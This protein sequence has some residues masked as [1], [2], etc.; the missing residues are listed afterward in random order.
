[1]KLLVAILRP[2]VIADVVE[3][4]QTLGI[5]GGTASEVSGFGAQKGHSEIYRGAEYQVTLVP[6]VRLEI[7][8][9]ADDVE[10]VVSAIDAIANTGKVGDGKIWVLSVDEVIRVRTGDRGLAAI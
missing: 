8:L 2:Y 7:V 5:S 10:P 1:M 9:S 4:L 3:A 6:K